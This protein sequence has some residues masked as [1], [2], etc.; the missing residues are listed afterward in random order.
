MALQLMILSVRNRSRSVLL[1]NRGMS[2]TERTVASVATHALTRAGRKPTAQSAYV[3]TVNGT[4]RRLSFEAFSCDGGD[5]QR[6]QRLSV[7]INVRVA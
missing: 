2:P 5:T 3:T 4:A 6:G 7:M 1:P